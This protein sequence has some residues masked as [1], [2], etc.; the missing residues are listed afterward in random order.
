MKPVRLRLGEFCK[1][2]NEPRETVRHLIHRGHAPIQPDSGDSAQRTYDAA[3]L[4]AWCLFTQ[5]RNLGLG[6][7][8]AGETVRA[9]FAADRFLRSIAPDPGYVVV[10]N[11]RYLHLY[12]LPSER[13]DPELGVRRLAGQFVGT[14]A[15][16]AAALEDECDRLGEIDAGDGRER[17]G[18]TGLVAAPIFPCW[19]RVLAT[20]DAHGFTVIG[21]NIFEADA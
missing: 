20:L 8:L 3:D 16:L 2:V 7:G 5:L 11:P 10:D 4:L 14:P 19:Q 17:M 1:M 9:T 12:I 13:R 18:A 15:D 6:A 21:R